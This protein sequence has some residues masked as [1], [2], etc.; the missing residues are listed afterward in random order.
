MLLLLDS[1]VLIDLLRSRRDRRQQVA[2]LVRAGHSLATSAINV[3]EI[4]AGV[5]ENERDRTEAFIS[6]LECLDATGRVARVAGD[7]KREW[8]IKGKTLTLADTFVA[9]TA[10]EYHCRL[11]TDNRKDFPMPELQ[12]HALP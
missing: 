1:S 8:A 3:A 12:F 7:L 2:E 10:L 11:I 5:R 9:A 4:Y 6:A